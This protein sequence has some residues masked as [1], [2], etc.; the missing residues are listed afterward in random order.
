[1]YSGLPVFGMNRGTLGFLMN[2]YLEELL[3]HRLTAAVARELHPLRMKT[4]DMD[5]NTS[6]ALA[7][8]EVSVFRQTRQAAQVR[9]SIDGTTRIDPLIS[10][11]VLVSTPAGST[12]YNA[13]AGGIM[14]PLDSGLLA[15]T[16]IC[17]FRPRRLRGGVLH[18]NA[19]VV[20]ECL[21]TSKRP[22]SATADFHEVR[23]AMWVEVEEARDISLQLLY[24]PSQDIDE[25]VWQEQFF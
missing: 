1:M 21:D 8:N 22:V 15:L 20:F 24:D 19:R 17:A 14:L 13:S 23:N 12:A 6:Y 3:L 5:G 10:D 11:G 4:V 18:R 25:K 9:V 2:E 16:P 7:F